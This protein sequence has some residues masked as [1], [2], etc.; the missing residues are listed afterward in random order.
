MVTLQVMLFSLN[1]KA[2][3]IRTLLKAE[4]VHTLPESTDLP[5]AEYIHKCDLMQTLKR[6]ARKSHAYIPVFDLYGD[7]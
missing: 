4:L 3:L 7:T 1:L 6:N 5:T 2:E